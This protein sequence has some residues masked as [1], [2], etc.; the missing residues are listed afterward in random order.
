M[1]KTFLSIS[2]FLLINPLLAQEKNI[3]T[4]S[5]PLIVMPNDEIIKDKG[6]PSVPAS[7]KISKEAIEMAN[8]SQA[9]AQLGIIEVIDNSLPGKWNL[10]SVTIINEINGKNLNNKIDKVFNEDY[11]LT[12]IE[13]ENSKKKRIVDKLALSSM[14]CQIKYKNISTNEASFIVSCNK[15]VSENNF[16]TIV[17]VTGKINTFPKNNEMILD[18]DLKSNKNGQPFDS[19][20]FTIKSKSKYVGSCEK[21]N[22]DF[23]IK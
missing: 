17:T 19:T 6:Y 16:S 1:K 7:R 14:N 2:L 20:K 23:K 12:K 4:K 15:V 18:Y 21:K 3:N 9:E 13:V 22:N 5:S 10:E 8:K 11:C